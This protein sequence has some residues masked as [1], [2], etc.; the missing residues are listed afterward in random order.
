[1]HILSSKLKLIAGF[2]LEALQR[3]N[4]L[5]PGHICNTKSNLQ[6]KFNSWKYAITILDAVSYNDSASAFCALVHLRSRFY[7]KLYCLAAHWA[8]ENKPLLNLNFAFPGASQHGGEWKVCY[9]F[10]IGL[11]ATLE[12]TSNFSAWIVQAP[13]LSIILFVEKTLTFMISFIS[14]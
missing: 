4:L 2:L 3:M 7:I 1:M 11:L 10:S 8:F 6:E 14:A 5:C 9:L 12:F 13:V